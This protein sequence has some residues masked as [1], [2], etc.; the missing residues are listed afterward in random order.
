[1]NYAMRVKMLTVK[2]ITNLKQRKKI[3]N[4][5]IDVDINLFEKIKK[6]RRN[7]LNN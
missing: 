2:I 3:L 7:Q 5:T 1:M 6:I 4:Y